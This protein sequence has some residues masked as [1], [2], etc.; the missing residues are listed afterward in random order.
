MSTGS[1]IF[2]QRFQDDNEGD[3]VADVDVGISVSNNDK[4]GG[5]GAG[6]LVFTGTV[7]GETGS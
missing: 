6:S 3:G 1:L 5:E 2:D 4:D 7:T